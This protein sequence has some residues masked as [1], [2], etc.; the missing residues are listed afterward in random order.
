M[1]SAK[2][3]LLKARYPIPP[4]KAGVSFPHPINIMACDLNYL[5]L[6]AL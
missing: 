4:L 2:K 6:L 5:I 3:Q 1:T